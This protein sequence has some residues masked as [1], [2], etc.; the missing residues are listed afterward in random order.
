MTINTS[1]ELSSLGMFPPELSDYVI[2]CVQHSKPTLAH[3]SLVCRAWLARS[4]YHLFKAITVVHPVCLDNL[5]DFLRSSPHLVGLISH[6]TLR[7][8]LSPDNINFASQFPV[9]VE[10]LIDCL[11]EL[12]SVR[13]LDLNGV[14]WTD[15]MESLS[16]SQ[17]H[18]AYSLERLRLSRV[19][20]SPDALFS[21]LAY[22]PELCSLRTEGI[23]W[24]TGGEHT[25]NLDCSAS[26]STA[27]QSVAVGPG[28]SYTM[29]KHFLPRLQQMFDVSTIQHL[30][31]HF[32]HL[33]PSEETAR[34]LDSARPR[35]KSLK[36]TLDDNTLI[37]TVRK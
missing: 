23:Y 21:T 17:K 26:A 8:S 36:I 32:N 29:M 12:P 33:D 30:T 7:G 31:L 4:R 35:L 24:T 19:F 6:L 9:S 11:H 37:N 27:L 10:K 5:I 16:P 14:W 18:P 2:D 25:E 15:G 20:V 1:T 3:C 22:F 13:E 28:C 34:F